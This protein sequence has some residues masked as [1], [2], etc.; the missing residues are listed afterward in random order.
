MSDKDKPKRKET[1]EKE[2]FF[3]HSGIISNN[4]SLNYK[5]IWIPFRCIILHLACIAQ[6]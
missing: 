1:G 2:I 3:E 6:Q 4:S 5:I